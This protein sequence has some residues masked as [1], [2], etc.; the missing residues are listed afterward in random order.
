MGVLG[1]QIN[2]FLE[3]GP[4][5]GIITF[6]GIDLPQGDQINNIFAVESQI[7]LDSSDGAVIILVLEKD[8]IQEFPG[9]Q[10]VRFDLQRLLGLFLGLSLFLIQQVGPG[11]EQPGLRVLGPILGEETETVHRGQAVFF[12]AGR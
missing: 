6:K 8:A 5:L 1:L 3:G 11:Q 7:T 10:K 2:D 4:G 12:V 9:I